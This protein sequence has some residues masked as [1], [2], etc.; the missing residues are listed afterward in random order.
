MWFLANLFVARWRVSALALAS[1]RFRR[2][3]YAAKEALHVWRQRAR[4]REALRRYLHYEFK[5]VPSD[6]SK[7]AWIEGVK[8]FWES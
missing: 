2:R 3:F 4:D 7:D 6:L 5:G 1:Y 8:R